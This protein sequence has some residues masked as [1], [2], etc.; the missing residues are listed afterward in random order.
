[1]AREIEFGTNV[2]GVKKDINYLGRDF[3]N[4]R[5]NLIE[6][7]KQYFPTAYN[8]FNEAS[9]GMMFIEMTAYVGDLLNFYID[10]QF[11]ESLLHSAEEK[12]NIFKIVQSMGYTPKLSNPSTVLAKVS[13]EVP[14]ETIDDNNYTVD[15]DY[16]PI[17]S[18]NSTFI[19]G[20]TDT[21]FRLMD[22]VNF[23][24]SS[25]FDP[26]GAVI[27]QTED[28]VPTHYKITKNALLQSGDTFIESFTFETAKKFD[29]IIL[30][31]NNVVEVTSC[32]DDDGN[33]WYNVPYL[34]QDTVFEDIENNPVNSPDMSQ[35]KD[36]TPYLMKLIKTARRFTTYVRSDGK[37]EIRFGSGISSNAD[38]EMIPNPDNVGSSLGTGISKLDASFDPS[39]FL[40]T[41]T[42][43]QAPGNITLTF[44]Y[45]HGGSITDNIL[46]EQLTDVDTGNVILNSEGLDAAKVTDVKDS[47]SITNDLPATGGSSGQ[48]IDEIKLSAMASMATQKRAVTLQ[49]YITRVYS[50]PQK[51][52]NIAKA[53]IVQDEQLDQKAGGD[54]GD[55]P[56]LKELS[57]P[58]ALNLYVLGYDYKRNFVLLNEA[59][60]TN[61]KIYLSQYRLVTDAI[62]IKDAFIIN[63]SVKFAIITQR[64]NNKNEV[65]MK[66]IDKVKNFF[67]VE[68]WQINQPII[69]SDIAYQISLVKGVASV[70]PPTE[71]NPEKSMIL[72]ENK[73]DIDAGY[74]GNVYDLDAATKE[75]VVYP[76]LDPCIFEIKFPNLDI[77]GKV[78]GDI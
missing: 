20:V 4:I 64:G 15:I 3:A 76:S 25:S 19:A 67:R 39:N 52:G 74:S 31:K 47:L 8:D 36:E 51:Y 22:D 29:K 7:A 54:D 10:N 50:L 2:K 68:K 77:E 66:C 60:K 34:A 23:K 37:T 59:T 57:N 32:I 17:V 33:K 43:G 38:E 78:V 11:R 65:L 73:Y 1:M 5:N 63:F 42:F 46:S 40:N 13:V 35:Y 56:D 16:A 9:P 61:L 26:R 48:S 24:T 72:I 75:G 58:L 14:A 44:T 6:F 55:K 41:K 12:K 18:A 70:V 62:N 71:D 53:H 69:L 27:S 30:S 28:D 21:K 45:T 49:D